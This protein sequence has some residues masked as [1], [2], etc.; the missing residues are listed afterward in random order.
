MAK[1]SPDELCPCQSGALFKECH[2][3][4]VKT[5]KPP[6]IKRRLP[7]KAIPEPDPGT[8]AVFEKIGD[9]TLFFQGFDTDLALVCGSCASVLVAGMERQQISSVVLHCKQCGSYNET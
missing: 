6:E 7:L 1:I 4:K 3:P 5:R 9:G 8:R 2:G